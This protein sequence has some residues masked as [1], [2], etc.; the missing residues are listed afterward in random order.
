MNAVLHPG[1][2]MTSYLCLAMYLLGCILVI[3]EWLPTKFQSRVLY[4]DVSSF[5]Y[6]S[7]TECNH[8]MHVQTLLSIFVCLCWSFTAQPTTRS[9]RGSQLIAALFQGRIR[10]SKRLTSTKPGHPRQ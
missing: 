7:S 8:L 6:C 4:L 9:C 1:V 2:V 5:K 3:C 10:P